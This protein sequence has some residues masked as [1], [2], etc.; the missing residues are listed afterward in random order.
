MPRLEEITR[1]AVV[2]GVLPFEIMTKDKYEAARTGNWF[3]ENPLATRRPDKLSRNEG[4]Q[5]KEVKARKEQRVDKTLAAVKEHLTVESSHWD[6]R[7]EQPLVR[8]PDFGVT[9]VNYKLAEQLA[10]GEAPR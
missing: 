4:G 8:E 10:K 3:T 7:A 5:E 1:G 2:K 6:H 9:S